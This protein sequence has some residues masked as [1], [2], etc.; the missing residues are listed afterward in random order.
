MECVTSPCLS[1]ACPHMY[2]RGAAVGRRA[3]TGSPAPTSV[4]PPLQDLASTA[5]PPLRLTPPPPLGLCSLGLCSLGSALLPGGPCWDCPAPAFANFK[6]DQFL[7]LLVPS[8]LKEMDHPLYIFP[9]E[10]KKARRSQGR[11]QGCSLDG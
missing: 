5:V 9:W 3:A 10:K 2:A 4:P 6:S 8:V 11:S 1:R 7:D